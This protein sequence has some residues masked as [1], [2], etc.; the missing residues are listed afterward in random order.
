MSAACKLANPC[1]VR[2]YTLTLSAGGEATYIMMSPVSS[3]VAECFRDGT[4]SI[5]HSDNSG[6]I[7]YSSDVQQ[8]SPSEIRAALSL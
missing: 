7:G 8:Q 4:R 3:V 5:F 1:N 2:T 6:L